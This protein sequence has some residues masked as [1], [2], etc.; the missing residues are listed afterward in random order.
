MECIKELNV[1]LTF[2]KGTKKENVLTINNEQ[3]CK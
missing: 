3:E 2:E 1:I